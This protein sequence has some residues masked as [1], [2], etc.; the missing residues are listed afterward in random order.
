M[1]FYDSTSNKSLWRGIDYYKS[2]KVRK[3]AETEGGLRGTVDGSNGETY[4]VVINLEHPR[5]STCNCPFAEGRKVICKHMIALYFMGTPGSYAAFEEDMHRMEVQQ[6][7][8]AKGDAGAYKER[9]FEDA[10]QGCPR[11]ASRHSFPAGPRRSLSQRR[12]VVSAT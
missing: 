6:R 10:R 5:K 11:K 4:D 1:T 3:H 7:L 9:C 2:G 8:E 12:L